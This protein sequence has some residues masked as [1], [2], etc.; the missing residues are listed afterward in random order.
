MIAQLTGSIVQYEA[1]A[2]IIDVNGVGYRVMALSPLLNGTSV[3]QTLQVHIHHHMTGEMEALYGFG[4]QEDLR[5]F[6]L[7][8]TV[9]SVGPKTAMAILE[10]APPTTLA[11]AV[12]TGDV[13]LLTKISGVGRKTADRILVEL[14]NKI[15]DLPA[16]LT[17]MPISGIVSD[18]QAETMSVLV[19]M[20]MTR[21]QAREVVQNLPVGVKSVEEAVKAALSGK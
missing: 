1:K 8:L 19:N 12:A 14:K 2:V 5:F 15:K 3:G 13:K 21:G 7:L 4:N 17:G 10:V 9:P 16:E 20:G 18:I 6:E 11:R